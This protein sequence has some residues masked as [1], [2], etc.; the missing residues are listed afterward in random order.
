MD[1]QNVKNNHTLIE[2]DM[3]FVYAKQEKVRVSNTLVGI[4]VNVQVIYTNS[5]NRVIKRRLFA[6]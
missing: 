6:V 2:K 5:N 1:F 3:A 4:T